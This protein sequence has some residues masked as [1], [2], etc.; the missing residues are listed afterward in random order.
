[1]T[2]GGAVYFGLKKS[3]SS[4]ASRMELLQL[5]AVADLV[6]FHPAAQGVDDFGGCSDT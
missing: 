1:M 6:P 5:R 4:R 3:S 2:R